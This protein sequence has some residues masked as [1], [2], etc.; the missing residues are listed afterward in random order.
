MIQSTQFIRRTIAIQTKIRTRIKVV[1]KRQPFVC[2]AIVTHPF[3][4]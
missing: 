4:M 2:E 3:Q 1:A